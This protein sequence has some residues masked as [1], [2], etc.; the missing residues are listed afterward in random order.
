MQIQTPVGG[1]VTPPSLPN[2]QQPAAPA[3]D[4]GAQIPVTPD[5]GVAPA[6]EDGGG[7]GENPSAQEPVTPGTETTQPVD[8]AAAA[9]AEAA[10]LEGARQAVESGAAGPDAAAAPPA[11]TYP[12]SAEPAA[13]APAGQVVQ[14]RKAVNDVLNPGTGD[15][16]A[17]AMALED[18][19]AGNHLETPD[20]S[21][22]AAADGNI[23]Q[24]A[25]TDQAGPEPVP[26]PPAAAS[27]ITPETP[28]N[29]TASETQPPAAP[30][31]EAVPPPPPSSP[32]LPDP[33]SALE[34]PLVD[35]TGMPPSPQAPQTPKVEVQDPGQLNSMKQ[36][37]EAMRQV[38]Q[39]YGDPNERP[40]SPDTAMALR[41]VGEAA[42]NMK[43][44]E[45]RLEELR[46]AF[47]AA[48][49][50]SEKDETQAGEA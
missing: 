23:G 35:T 25:A 47:E 6:V 9:A 1:E 4:G 28:D 34:R 2:D 20:P 41:I 13:A 24:V 32:P 36:A 21:Q 27:V 49:P 12:G 16:A 33:A 19:V 5:T 11:Q 43:E 3:V 31:G 42:R 37:S 45:A 17:T 26:A 30:G 15:P 14:D 38:D 7:L 40:T 22:E 39:A 44:A 8:A 50:G 29:L 48:A 46:R 18:T 10:G